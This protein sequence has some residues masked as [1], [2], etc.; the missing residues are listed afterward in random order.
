MINKI[1]GRDP[2][3]RWEGAVHEHLTY[4]STGKRDFT[5]FIDLTQDENLDV[6]HYPDLTRDR[7]FYRDLARERI[8][9]HPNDYQAITLLANEERVKGDPQEAIYLYERI[10]N[11]FS[12]DMSPVELAAVYFALGQAQE[13][14]Q[15]GVAAMSSYSKGIGI[16]KYY[17]DNYYAL[18]VLMV[19]NEL[20][21]M[22]I[23]ILEEALNSTQRFYF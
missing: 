14:I 18:G 22:A 7:L 1:H 6:H 19:K 17:R 5:E 10:I 2:D 15:D 21:H 20:P 8:E 11:N 12:N 13:K 4:M 9:E 23:G 3:L 16:N